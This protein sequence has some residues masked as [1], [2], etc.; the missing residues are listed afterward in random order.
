MQQE[1]QPDAVRRM[2]SLDT[3]VS[4]SVTGWVLDTRY[5]TVT[6]IRPAGGPAEY[7]TSSSDGALR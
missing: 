5:G 3:P 7:D 1:R 4:T 2:L 6:R